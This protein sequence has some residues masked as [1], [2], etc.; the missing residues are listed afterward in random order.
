MALPI[1]ALTP[2]EFGASFWMFSLGNLVSGGVKAMVST[3][4]IVS[5]QALLANH[6]DYWFK[7]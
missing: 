3:M 7:S 6:G 1:V 5:F 4:W 2:F